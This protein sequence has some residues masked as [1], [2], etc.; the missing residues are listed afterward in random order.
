[1]FLA[2]RE[3]EMKTSCEL[4][5]VQRERWSGVIII[6]EKKE[7]EKLFDGLKYQEIFFGS[8]SYLS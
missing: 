5:A 6:E 3:L 7:S 1:M 4:S 8:V 2:S